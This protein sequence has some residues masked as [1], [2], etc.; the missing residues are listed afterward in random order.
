[1]AST[2]HALHGMQLKDTE[3]S[4][5]AGNNKIQWILDNG[6]SHHMTHDSC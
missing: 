6:A 2:C 4:N 1:M 5:M 3:P